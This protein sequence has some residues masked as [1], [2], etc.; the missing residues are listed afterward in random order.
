MKYC[1]LNIFFLC[2][3]ACSQVVTP[4]KKLLSEE[5]MEA[6]FYDLALLNAAKSIDATFYEQSGILTSTM[7]YKKYGVD[8]L[9]LAENISYYSSNPQ[10]CNKILSAVSMRLNKEDSL[11]QKQLTPPQPPSPQEELP[12]DTLK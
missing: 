10:K 4:P 9:Q 6:V 3:I 11:L 2:L 7:L 8:S 1:Y 5:E 12:S